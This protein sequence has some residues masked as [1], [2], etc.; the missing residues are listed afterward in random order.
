M[1]EPARVVQVVGH[2][3][4]IP[5]LGRHIQYAPRREVIEGGAPV[6]GLRQE[7]SCSVSSYAP[8]TTHRRK[9]LAG[10]KV[11]LEYCQW[12]FFPLVPQHAEVA[13]L[14][15]EGAQKFVPLEKQALAGEYELEKVCRFK[16]K[17]QPRHNTTPTTHLVTPYLRN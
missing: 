9:L 6:H 15:R 10:A 1:G 5:V 3:N 13:L 2:M 7:A 14:L 8:H 16:Q 12:P 11:R 4:D 17:R